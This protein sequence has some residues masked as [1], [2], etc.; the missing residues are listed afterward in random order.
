MMKYWI[1]SLVTACFVSFQQ[2]NDLAASMERGKEIYEDF[3][4]ACHQADGKGLPGAFPPLANS[5]YLLNKR[6][7]SIRAVK[8]GQQGEIVVNDVTYNAIMTPLYLADDEVAD[9]M[10][11]ILHSWENKGG[12]MVT[13]EE[14]EK[15]KEVEEAKE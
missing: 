11:Y 3:C 2:D 7:A 8:Y 14:V 9:V 1:I 4:I 12:E 5:D 15:V 13:L 10:N 6:E